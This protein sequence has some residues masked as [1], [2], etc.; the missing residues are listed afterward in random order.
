MA[1][2]FLVFAILDIVAG[3]EKEALEGLVK[4]LEPEVGGRFGPAA[5]WQIRHSTD[6]AVELRLKDPAAVADLDDLLIDKVRSVDGIAE[7]T[8]RT[9]FNF[10]FIDEAG[11]KKAVAAARGEGGILGVVLCDVVCGKDRETHQAMLALKPDGDVVP[12]D[13]ETAFHSADFDASVLLVG[14]DEGALHAYIQ[15]HLRPIDGVYDTFCEVWSI[16]KVFGGE[17]AFAAGWQSMAG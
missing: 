15:K 11:G 8:I 12:V 17:E 2:E 10:S 4:N 16:L 1:K 6:Y 9:I 13:V 7:T 14:P 5:I 3:K